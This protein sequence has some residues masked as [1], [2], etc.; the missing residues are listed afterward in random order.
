MITIVCTEEEMQMLKM[1]LRITD[2]DM[3][4]PP[5]DKNGLSLDLNLGGMIHWIIGEEHQTKNAWRILND[6]FDKINEKEQSE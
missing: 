1:E 6:N 3:L 5:Y 2:S 4:K